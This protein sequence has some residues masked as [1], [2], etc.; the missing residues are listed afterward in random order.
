MEGSV[1]PLNF[2]HTL[3]HVRKIFPRNREDTLVTEES[4]EMADKRIEEFG[5]GLVAAEQFM[6]D[7][8]SFIRSQDLESELTERQLQEFI[9]T[10][11][12]KYRKAKTEPGEAVGAVAA[13]SIG[14]PATQ[15]TLKT[16]HF[17]GVASMNVTLGVPR[18]KE[19]I[20][21]AKTISTPII[22]AALVNDRSEPSARVVA[23]R[24]ERT[25]IGDIAKS[26]KVVY[27]V[28][29]VFVQVHFDLAAINSAQLELSL[30]SIREEIVAKGALPARLKLKQESIEIKGKDTLLI[31][32]GSVTTQ[33]SL[34][35][36]LQ[37]IKSHL[38]AVP[39]RGIKQA[40]RVVINK[41]ATGKGAEEELSLL[42]EGYG[43]Q[44]VMN[45]L[46]VKGEETVGNHVAEVQAVLGI[47]AARQIIVGEVLKIM[48]H[49]G[50]G[51]DNR[52]VQLLG[53]QMTNTGD[54]L[55]INRFGISKMRQ[56]TLMLASFEK[57]SDHLFDAAVHNRLDK[58]EGV[59]ESIIMGNPMQVGTGL[60]KLLYSIPEDE[61]AAE[62][63]ENG[64]KPLL[65]DIIE[66][67]IEE[68]SAFS[69]RKRNI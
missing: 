58:V 21:A 46:G 3:T 30:E 34:W 50:I 62:V 2:S 11:F 69:K 53:D 5:E 32:P 23:G 57:T 7:L 25:T 31:R 67:L 38:A 13:Q 47:E 10:C 27:D 4:F 19:I 24:V 66:P 68:D 22:T 41:S 42:V 44:E 49:H 64:R 14:E 29:D 9:K 18:I 63:T 16:F 43:L 45:T 60:F 28:H 54:V 6:E 65:V 1:K 37:L 26:I 52:H 51:V 15:M 59:S 48:K 8:S 55:G 36:D 33:E 12:T 20:N 17:A 61:I 56:S 39:V 35:F 40:K